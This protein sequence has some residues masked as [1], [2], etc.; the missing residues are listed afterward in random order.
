M[1]GR[2]QRQSEAG[3]VRHSI[4]ITEHEDAFHSWLFL[5]LFC[6]DSNVCFVFK[7][8]SVTESDMKQEM[9]RE[10]RHNLILNVRCPVV[11][12]LP[13]TIVMWG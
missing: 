3:Q 2:V 4:V 13:Q 9:E 8:M 7:K 1:I 11:V 10:C 6:E 5:F 12:L